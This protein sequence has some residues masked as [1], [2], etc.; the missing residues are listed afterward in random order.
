MSHGRSVLRLA[1]PAVM[2]LG[3]AGLLVELGAA[4]AH[5]AVLPPVTPVADAYVQSD[6]PSAN[7]GTALTLN[8]V[9]GTPE[10]RA[11]LKFDLSGV[12]GTI[13]KATFRVFTQTSSGSGYELHGVA[14]TGWSETGVTYANRPAVGST[15]G[16]AVNITANT[17]TMVDVTSVVTTPGVYSFEMNATSANLKQ[18]ASR[19][20]GANA[21]QLV[22]ETAAPTNPPAAIAAV[23]GTPQSTTINTAF[24][25]ALTAKVTDAGG[26]PVTGASVTF[27]APASGASGTF[28]GGAPSATATSGTDGVAKAP[29]FTANA[30][31]GS[32]S[33]TATVGG[34][35][36][37]ATFNLTNTA[38]TGPT[39]VT[40]TVGEDS[41]VQADLAS[42]SFGTASV[43]KNVTSPDTRAY[44]KFG[45]TVNGTIT[46][47]TFR[48][49]TQ[50]SSGSGYELH[51]VADNTWSSSTLTYNNRP[52]VGTTIGTATNIVA[53]TWT[54]VDVTSYVTGNGTYSMEMNATSTSVKQYSSKEGANPAQ[55]VLTVTPPANAAT[56]LAVSAGSNQSAAVGTSFATNLA[57]KATDSGG[58]PVAGTTVTFT[59]PSSGASGTFAGGSTTATA[60]TAA[61]GVATAPVFTANAGAGTYTVTASASGVQTP[62]TFSLTNTAPGAP[63]AA[64]VADAYVQADQPDTNF[65]NSQLLIGRT[66]PEVDSFLKFTVANVNQQP[67]KATLRMWSQATGPNPVKVYQVTDN[68]W[69]EQGVT[70]ATKPAF[71][72][73]IVT[74]GATTAGAWLEL[75]VTGAITGSG[76]V[77]FG[78]TSGSTVGKTFSSRED[79]AHAPELVVQAPPPSNGDPVIAAVGDIACDP[80]DPNWNNNLGNNGFCHHKA[81]SDQ[82][83]ALGPQWMLTLGDHQYNGGTASQFA[84]SYDPTWGRLKAITR[85]ALGNHEF[86]TS[87]ASGYFNYFG[88]AATPLDPTCR[89]NCNAWYSFDV[90]SWHIVALNTEC[91]RNNGNCAAGSAQ[92]TWLRNDLQAHPNACTLVYT[93]HPK[94]ASSSFGETRIDALLQVMYDNNVDLMLT[95]HAHYYE[96]FAPQNPQSQRDDARGI[97]QIIVGTG[98][99][100][101]SGFSTPLPNSLVRNNN[102]YGIM[103]LTLHPNSADFQFLRESTSIG[104]L[105][106][107]GTVSCH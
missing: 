32:Y 72:G 24:S 20:S 43:L 23:G 98:G 34:V 2:V 14:D 22:V 107:S 62:A 26:Q 13:T 21:P 3:L 90:G 92:E 79:A 15:I 88:A 81:T 47:A 6:Q 7:F 42:T 18:Y 60:T 67:A 4:R 57:A 9:S 10:A 93:H 40:V 28:A 44:L 86:G 1:M 50:T 70:F 39:T 77:T 38:A 71:G 76:T 30:A 84:A 53:N 85:P 37:P 105:A 96:R 12:T 25:T 16:S 59:A 55:L 95:G 56:T 51:R 45:V 19:E 11:Y 101:F 29:T 89:S 75:D 66:S 5:A 48:A 97:T 69:T 103:K 106:D 82:A 46:T 27:T 61:D 78:F 64:I 104:F 36:S 8:N 87:G 68:S 63:T 100:D 83:L 33:V 49:Y 54:S 99:R 91:D 31:T 17:W 52:A 80:T 102:T 58:N 73:L 41:Y 74:S 94:W 65:G 35:A